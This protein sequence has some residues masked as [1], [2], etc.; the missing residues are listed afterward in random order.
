[1]QTFFFNENITIEFLQWIKTTLIIII[2]NLQIKRFILSVKIL[3]AIPFYQYL[4]N[5][6]VS[7]VLSKHLC[8]IL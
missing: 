4:V 1:M 2:L 5:T 6:T 7:T 8:K 3:P